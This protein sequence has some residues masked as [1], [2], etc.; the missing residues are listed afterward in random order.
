VGI[1][2]LRCLLRTRSPPAAPSLLQQ[3]GRRSARVAPRHPP[4]QQLSSEQSATD[5]NSA[6]PTGGDG[7]STHSSAWPEQPQ[8]T[9]SES[10][11]END[12]RK[13]VSLAHVTMARAK[14]LVLLY[15][16]KRLPTNVAAAVQQHARKFLDNL[17]DASEHVSSPLKKRFSSA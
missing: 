15:K 8:H 14:A 9:D 7:G 12:N 10:G 2:S 16:G 4:L 1:A 11:R 17:L 13:W 5:R 3:P 6:P